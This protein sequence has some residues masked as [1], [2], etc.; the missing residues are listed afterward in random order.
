MQTMCSNGP[1]PENPTKGGK[2]YHISDQGRKNCNE[3]ENTET[4][5]SDIAD[6]NEAQE[7][8]HEDQSSHDDSLPD[9]MKSGFNCLFNAFTTDQTQP[10]VC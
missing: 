6:R 4:G 1:N 10:V 3:S 2:Q 5:N 9:F 8:R 7:E